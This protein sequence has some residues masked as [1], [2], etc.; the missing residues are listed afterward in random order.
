MTIKVCCEKLHIEYSLSNTVHV[1]GDGP[2]MKH[3]YR[4]QK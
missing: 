2:H 4:K 1:A 3:K